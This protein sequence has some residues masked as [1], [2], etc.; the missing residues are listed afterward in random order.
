MAGQGADG[1]K[2]LTFNYARVVVDKIASYLM[3]GVK[4]VI[5]PGERHR[6]RQRE[7]TPRGSRI[8]AGL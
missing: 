2:R 6:Y 5:D 3:S 7:S 1:E 4:F 8:T